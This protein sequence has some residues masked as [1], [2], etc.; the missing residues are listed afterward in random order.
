MKTL[1]AFLLASSVAF[2]TL[3]AGA[4]W[5]VRTG[6]NDLNGGFFNTAPG[7]GTD[8]SQQDAAQ[9]SV[10]DGVTATTTLSSVTG[11]FTA[12]M[13]HNGVQLSGGTCTAG[14]YE[15]TVVTNTNTVTID[16]TGGTGTGCT[17]KVGGGLLTLAKA[18]ASGSAVASN[19][20]WIKAGTYTTTTTTTYA[21]T[22]NA[23]T[24][25]VVTEGYQTTHGDVGTKPL[26]TSA[27]NSVDVISL[28]GGNYLVFRNL[29]ISSTAGTR[30]ACYATINNVPHDVII[31]RNVMD[32]C[33]YGVFA[34]NSPVWRLNGLTV[35]NSEI[36]NTGTA[37][38]LL[39][40][41]VVAANNYIHDNVVGI[42]GNAGTS[43][44]LVTFAIIGNVFSTNT[45]GVIVSAANGTI[46]PFIGNSF[47]NNTLGISFPGST[48]A[49]L[50]TGAFQNNVFWAN[51]S[52]ING[53][54]TSN[55]GFQRNAIGNAYNNTST[56]WIAQQIAL[57]AIPFTAVGSADFSPNSTA[58]G[59]A[60]LKAVGWPGVTGLFGTGYLDI[61]ALQSQ[62][63]GGASNS[64]YA[65]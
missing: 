31:D 43:D 23:A 10:T 19:F 18:V 9:L 17:V 62:A 46:T 58:G 65:Q 13:L 61:G 25:P 53:N 45:T 26:I 48:T 22:A 35:T 39:S 55:F 3:P 1:L 63:G 50:D 56:G 16:R 64:A 20:I 42:S 44:A 32:G 5:E 21:I 57:T 47:Y 38:M 52:N 2:A 24:G 8:Y 54:T 49:P 7:T 36:K 40:A 14:F 6:G 28:N 33:K 27:T 37:G 59:G 11:G 41:G 12:A 30:G 60:A 34:D 51:T 29:S 15:I 4:N